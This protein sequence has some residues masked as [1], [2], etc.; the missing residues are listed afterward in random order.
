[1]AD[2]YIYSPVKG[3]IVEKFV[4]LGEHVVPGT[5]AVLVID[6]DQLYIKTYVEE[7]HIGKVKYNSPARIYVDSF[8]D[9][10]FEG[11]ITFIAPKA[12]FTPRDVQME[13]HR[14]R[15]VYKVEVGI[16]NPEGILKPGMPADVDLKWDQDKSWE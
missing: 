5:P 7:I 14:S 11:K 4:E 6:M 16:L 13:E 1:M 15:I 3:T 12:E 2:T 10:Y 8:P 9:R